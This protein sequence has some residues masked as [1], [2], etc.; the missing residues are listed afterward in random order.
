MTKK[1]RAKLL[2][3]S[4]CFMEDEPRFEGDI[5]DWKGGFCKGMELLSDVLISDAKKRRV[6]TFH[7][8]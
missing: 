3:A 8:K 2:L 6:P 7:G 5:P 4:E 1:E